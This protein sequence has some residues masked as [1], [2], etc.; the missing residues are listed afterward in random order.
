MAV[1][2]F[3]GYVRFIGAESK[4]DGLVYQYTFPN[5]PSGGEPDGFVFIHSAT[6]NTKNVGDLILYNA[7]DTTTRSKDGRWVTIL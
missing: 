4:E 7:D 2:D 5:S 3:N 1:S 6:M